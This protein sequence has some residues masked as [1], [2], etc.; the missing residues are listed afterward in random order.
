MTKGKANRE[1]NFQYQRLSSW[2]LNGFSISNLHS[3]LDTDQ[4][5]EKTRKGEG[6]DSTNCTSNVARPGSQLRSLTFE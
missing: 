5:D 4:A 6:N 2:I 3:S 1:T